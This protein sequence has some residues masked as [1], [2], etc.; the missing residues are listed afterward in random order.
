MQLIRHSPYHHK[1]VELGAEFVDRMG[2]AAPLKFSSTEAEHRATREAVGVFDVYYQVPVEVAGR[3]AAG[4]LQHHLVADIAA[5]PVGKVVYSSLC[6]ET[7]GMIDDLTCFRLAPDRLWLFPTPSRIEAVVATLSKDAP[8]ND[9]MVC[10]LGYKTAYLSVQ[11]P[12]S[13]EL[14]GKL[15]SADLSTSALPYYSFVTTTVADVPGTLLSRTG[16]SGE[17]GYELFYPSECA[18]H[19]WDAVMSAG[20]VLGV[21]P[22]GLGALR[23]LRI[24]KKYP[25]Y[26]LDLDETT[27]PFEAGLGWTV[28]LGK[29]RFAA[30][31]ALERQKRE[32]VS[33]RLMLVEFD[34]LGFLPG[35]GDSIS[36]EGRK[37]GSVTSS[38]RGYAVGKSLALGYVAAQEALDGRRVIV[39]TA[40]GGRSE[41]IM[42]ERAVYDPSG[43][44]V[45]S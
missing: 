39:D 20:A 36:V 21:T 18:E 23:S 1:F 30:R 15:S 31:E 34:G 32:G 9:C 33:R 17:L 3:G 25:L 19:L 43:G 7:G 38:D 45:R 8:A 22:C 28:K 37:I 41:G 24:E 6:N 11:G 35:R 5:L 16:Y 26:G 12:R 4:L 14:I 40:S 13:R 10:N 44:R 42:R 27:S 2:M 29:P